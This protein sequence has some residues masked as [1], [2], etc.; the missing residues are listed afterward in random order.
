MK[1]HFF[2]IVWVSWPKQR[3]KRLSSNIQTLG[4]FSIENTFRYIENFSITCNTQ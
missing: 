4:N 3:E 2:G 1:P